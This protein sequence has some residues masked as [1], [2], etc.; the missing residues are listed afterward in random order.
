MFLTVIFSL[1]FAVT[2]SYAVG[3]NIGV[4][5]IQKLMTDLPKVGGVNKKLNAR[6][7]P[8]KTKLEKRQKSLIALE[9]KLNRDSSVMQGKERADLEGKIKK[10]RQ[11]LIPMMQKFQEKVFTTQQKELKN[12]ADYIS[13]LIKKVAK[14]KNIDLVLNKAV[15]EYAGDKYD[16][17]KDILAA[18]K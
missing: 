14:S 8:E 9:K 1:V 13:G 16:L 10:E 3:A 17:T 2:M 12:I 4:V 11:E 5:D 7:L 6:F 15:V 18:G